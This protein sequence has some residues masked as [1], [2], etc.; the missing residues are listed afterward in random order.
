MTTN[1]RSWVVP[2]IAEELLGGKAFFVRDGVFKGVDA[3]LFTHVANNLSTSWGYAGGTGLVSVEFTFHGESAHSAQVPWRGR[4]ALD[5]V[6]LMTLGWEMRRE[7]LR[8]EQRSH[9]VIRDGGDQPNVVPSG[10]SVWFYF[11]EQTFENISKNFTIANKIADG[12]AMMTDTSITRRMLGSASSTHWM[13]RRPNRA[14]AARTTSAMCR[15]TYRRSRY[16]IQ[17]TSRICPATCG[18]TRSR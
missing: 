2:G 17:P 7:H 15:G 18:P 3:V 10:A 16:A 1:N 8:P 4:S 9:F 11:R 12:A 14:A 13:P 6:E 5:G